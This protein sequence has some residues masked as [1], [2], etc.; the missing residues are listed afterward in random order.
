VKGT[1]SDTTI[2]QDSLPIL[3]ISCWL[4]AVFLLNSPVL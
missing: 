2:G 3:P 1:I 4:K